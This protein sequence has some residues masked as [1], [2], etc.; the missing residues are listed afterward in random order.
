M[1]VKRLQGQ[2]IITSTYLI[3]H[4]MYNK[5]RNLFDTIL[6]LHPTHMNFYILDDLHVPVY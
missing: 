5:P 4:L 3:I 6:Q 2:N 1:S